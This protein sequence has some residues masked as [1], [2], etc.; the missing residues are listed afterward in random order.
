MSCWSY[1]LT[2]TYCR[3]DSEPQP[4]TTLN[5]SHLFISYLKY[6]LLS[7]D[8]PFWIG[9][10]IWNFENIFWASNHGLG[11]NHTFILWLQ[12]WKCL[13]TKNDFPRKQIGKAVLHYFITYLDRRPYFLAKFSARTDLNWLRVVFICLYIGF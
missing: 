7:W 3:S 13:F 4:L 11:Q 5:K 9:R 10:H 8:I 2:F 6:C 1:I 12:G